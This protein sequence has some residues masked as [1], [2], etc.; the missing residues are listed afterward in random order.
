MLAEIVIKLRRPGNAAL[1]KAEIETWEP[2]RHAAHEQGPAEKLG[3]R[4]EAAEMVE[5]I[6]GR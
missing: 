5:H 2:V 3:A 6:V 1:Q 4:R